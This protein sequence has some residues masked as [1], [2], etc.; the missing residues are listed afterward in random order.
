MSNFLSDDELRAL[1]IKKYGSD[2]RIGRFAILY[3]PELLTLGNHVRI[4]DFTVIS[5]SVT[6]GSY[7]HISQ[8]C[9]IYGGEKGIIMEDFSGLSSKCTIYATSDDYSGCSMTNPTV[10]DQFKPGYIDK[11][12]KIARHAVI[13]CSSVVLPGVTVDEG[14]S[15]GSMTLCNKTTDPWSIYIG[16]PARKVGERKKDILKMEQ[17]L[18]ENGYNG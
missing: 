16:I 9:G 5:G 7:I 10:P 11:S 14:T 15:I 12:V 6:L 17:Q 2:I 18:W 3:T 8:F 13:G 4:D 1:G